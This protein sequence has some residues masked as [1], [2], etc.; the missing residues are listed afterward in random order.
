MDDGSEPTTLRT[1]ALAIA[2]TLE[3]EGCD[4]AL[5]FELAGLTLEDDSG[6]DARYPVSS[7]T[8]LW[9][10]A[11]KL[12]GDPAIGLKVADYVQPANLHALGLALLASETL[13]DMIRRVARYS[14]IVT[15]AV[16]IHV[17]HLPRR[18][19]ISYAVPPHGPALAH[20]AFDA[21]LALTVKMSCMLAQKD[22]RPLRVELTRPPPA[23]VEPYRDRFRAPI[24]F[25]VRESRLHYE[26]SVLAAPLPTAN[27]ALVH[28]N[29]QI[30]IDYLAR[31]DQSRVS[32]RVRANILERLASGS[33]LRLVD[34][35]A[36]MNMSARGL[37]R[38]LFA[39]RISYKA[40][41]DRTRLE[42]ADRYLQ[43]SAL[44]LGDIT[45]LLGFDDQSNFTRTFKR[46]TGSTPQRYRARLTE[47]PGN[48]LRRR[49]QGRRR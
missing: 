31:F 49:V 18:V 44:S 32:L 42:L 37:Q 41:V 40:I 28:A 7:M 39:E 10:A 6:A 47:R 29:E 35:A 33:S 48:T 45:H 13:D 9:R 34:V 3:G 43:Q 46:W 16:V 26:P 2:R 38:R 1:W 8:R 24:A 25:G 5:A 30:V 17:A 21:L 23:D 36:S 14:R 20:E 15:D 22:V 4:P 11:V 27:P 19:I 12:S